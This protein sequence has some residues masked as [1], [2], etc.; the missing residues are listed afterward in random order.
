MMSYKRYEKYKDSGVEWIGEVPEGWGISKIKYTSD[1]KG[2]IGWQGLR[3]DEF[4]DEG[5]FLVTGT[6]FENG[7][8]NWHTCYHIS[9]ER[10]NEAPPIQL[11]N[12]D[13]LITKDGTI[14]K[15]AIVKNKPDKA[16]L[17][18]GIFV[19]RPLSNKYL[20]R[21]MFWLLNSAVF[22][23]YIDYT[24]TGST[25]V[26]L[27]QE[28]FEN[29]S[30]P[31]PSISEQE[32]IVEFLNQR[33]SKFDSLIID[34]EKLI[35]L[36]QEKRQAIISE[37]I[38]KGLDN[39]VKM[40]DSGIEWI[41]EVPEHWNL[42]PLRW[43]I[44]I[45]SGDFISKDEMNEDGKYPVIGGNGITNYT[46]K[47]NVDQPTIAIG[48]VGALCGNI[49][50][51][52]EKSWITDNALYLPNW[53]SNKLY[54]EYLQLVLEVLNL[55]RFASKTAQPL[56]TGELIKK[57]YIPIPPTFDE[58][59]SICKYIKDNLSSLDNMIQSIQVQVRSLI[60]YRQALISEVVTGK[61][62]V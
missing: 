46:D 59:I 5:P 53:Q 16:I 28:T 58:Q 43:L 35:E 52:N 8:I 2:R 3:A 25:I 47:V 62:M 4:M 12:G 60:E 1:V 51:I 21:Y 44:S 48:R 56:I 40:K 41:G 38:T 14:G 36:L 45:R 19:I 7:K 9:L 39:N 34:K 49:H 61:I 23:I 29:F 24:K 33:T 27:Y 31:L 37:A 15:V 6:D 13:L 50:L 57:Q 22:N 42:S 10:Y 17:N 26:H 30:F 32:K 54:L 11:K 55:N 20:S 18:S